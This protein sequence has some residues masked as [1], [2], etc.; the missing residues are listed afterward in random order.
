MKRIIVPTDFS[1]AAL[2]ATNYALDM[3]IALNAEIILFHALYIPVTY[4]DI[5]PAFSPEELQN[6]VKEKLEDLKQQLLHRCSHSVSIKTAVAVGTLLN[7]LQI[8]CKQLD[9]YAVVM[10]SQGASATQYDFFGSHSANTMRYLRWP[11]ITVP[12]GVK[13]NSVKKIGLAC[14]FQNVMDKIPVDEIERL[15]KEFKSE[16]YVINT[17]KSAVHNPDM[18]LE[19]GILQ[20]MLQDLQ[21]RYEFITNKDI[22]EGIMD[23]CEKNNIDLLIVMPKRHTL[24]D[25]LIHRS[26]TKQLVLQSHVPVMALHE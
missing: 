23:F 14:D 2:S 4:T 26:H 5:P 22:D 3:A 7:E 8:L 19:S 24:L 21:P 16:L 13:F 25:K 15:V 18:I 20:V 1:A 10:G 12:Q 11:V 9:A 6:E 17:D